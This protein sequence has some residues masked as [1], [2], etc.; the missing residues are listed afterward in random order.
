MARPLVLIHG[1]SAEGK[2]FENLKQAL[3]KRGIDSK[4]INIC[5][6]VSL[7]NEVTIKDIAEAGWTARSECTRSSATRRKSSMRL[8]IRPGCWCCAPGW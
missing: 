1:Y 3:V 4:D 6:Y 8:C 7:N 5:N 2:D